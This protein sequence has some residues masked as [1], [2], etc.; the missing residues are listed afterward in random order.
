MIEN[1]FSFFDL[2]LVILDF[3]INPIYNHL[4]AYDTG[5][6][7][8]IWKIYDSSLFFTDTKHGNI[9]NFKGINGVKFSPINELLFT[10][11]LDGILI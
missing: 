9:P 3:I 1:T 10:Y 11:G 5:G 8:N 2:S 7:I 6:T 4:I